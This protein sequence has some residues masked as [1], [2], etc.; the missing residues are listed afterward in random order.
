MASMLS[1][2]TSSSRRCVNTK[3]QVTINRGSQV[4]DA[5]SI[6][7]VI[8]LAATLHNKLLLSAKGRQAKET[9]NAIAQ[10]FNVVC[11]I[12]YKD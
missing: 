5:T 10:R 3:T 9:I 2:P 11:V 6:F 12:D 1:P 4:A 8:W 7:D